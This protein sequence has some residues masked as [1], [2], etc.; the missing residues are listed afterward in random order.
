MDYSQRPGDNE[1]FDYHRNYVALVPLGNILE[2][3]AEQRDAI[4][5]F[6][7]SIDP[8]L[9]PAVH[10]PYTW[11]VQTVIEH[12][13]DAERVFGYR[14]M[15]FAAGDQADLPG[16]DENRYAASGYGKQVNRDGL[17]DELASI[18]QAN[19]CLLRRLLPECWD[20]RGTAD[21]RQV[22]VRTLAWLM[23][24]HWCHH[25]AILKKRLA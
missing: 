16:W 2:T 11:S 8:S 19:L 13:C 3:L 9:M 21:G 15:R 25:E 18:R 20:R 7:N 5:Q 24:G 23:A 10:A 22:S 17:I 12:C 14:A 4:S 1:C 6:L